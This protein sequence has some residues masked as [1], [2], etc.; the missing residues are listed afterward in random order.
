MLSI[1]VFALPI[2]IADWK[3][4]KI[5]NIYLLFILYW[6]GMS[7]LFSGVRSPVTI[8]LAILLAMTA[9]VFLGMGMGDAKYFI[10]IC[11]AL[12]VSHATQLVILIVGIY[13]A[14]A[15]GIC[16][17]WLAGHKF[18]DSIPLAAP[19]VMGT[20]LYLAASSSIPLQQYADALVNSW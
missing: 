3:Y 13:I 15:G 16:I 19:I 2:A 12:N 8:A 11:L 5:P 7:R 4:R 14:S 6:V 20:T 9:V 10:L 17:S 1:A 18:P